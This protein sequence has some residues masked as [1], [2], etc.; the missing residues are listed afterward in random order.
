MIGF[1]QFIVPL[2]TKTYRWGPQLLQQLGHFLLHAVGLRQ[3]GNTGLAQ[4]FVL[5]HVGGCRRIVSGLHRVLRRL[6][7][8]LLCAEHLAD[9]VQGVDLSADVAVLSRHVSDGRVQ[10][11]QGGL[12]VG[13][14]GEGCTVE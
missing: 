2:A 4:N 1:T 12:R 8:L 14:I 5:G 11:R 7:V 10:A 3:R 9:G 6:H 13:C